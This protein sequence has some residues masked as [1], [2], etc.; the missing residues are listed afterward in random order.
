MLSEYVERR[1]GVALGA[2]GSLAQMLH[3]SLGADTFSGFWHHWNPIWG[4]YLG[5]F[6]NAPLRRVMPAA[7]AVVATFIVSGA[8]HDAAIFAVT[9][10]P[11]A[12]FVPSFAVLGLMVVLSKRFGIRYGFQAWRVRAVINVALVVGPLALVM[13]GKQ[14]LGFA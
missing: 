14:L 8:I 1:N 7:A 11:T 9:G 12:L 6:V 10:S 3:R 5:R 4:Y 2:R 13:A